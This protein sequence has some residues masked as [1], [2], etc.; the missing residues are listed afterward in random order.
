MLINYTPGY[1]GF[2]F[3][4]AV[5]KGQ[6]LLR[7][8]LFLAG[9][10]GKRKNNLISEHFLLLNSL[11]LTNPTTSQPIKGYFLAITYPKFINPWY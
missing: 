3:Y 9:G 10:L 6:C 8:A 7:H 5:H 4:K 11:I 2:D 1:D